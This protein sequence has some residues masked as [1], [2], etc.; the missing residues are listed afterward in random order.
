MSDVAHETRVQP[1]STPVAPAAVVAAPTPVAAVGSHGGT[2]QGDVHSLSSV[3]SG[4]S[5]PRNS[6]N[7]SGDQ[8]SGGSFPN[9]SSQNWRSLGGF[10]GGN[11][12]ADTPQL[13]PKKPDEAAKVKNATMGMPSIGNVDL[14][15][16]PVHSSND[17][18]D[19]FYH[20]STYGTFTQ[21]KPGS[22]K[23]NKDGHAVDLY[24]ARAVAGVREQVGVRGT[25]ETTG[26][27]GSAK[28]TG[29]AFALAE[30]GAD[31]NASIGSNGI[32]GNA[33]ASARA[34]IGVKG[35]ADLKSNALNIDGVD[36]LYA[37][38]GTH[39]DGFAEPGP[40]RHLR[41]C[42]HHRRADAAPHRLDAD[43][44]AADPVQF[45]EQRSQAP[46]TA[47]RGPGGECGLAGQGHHP[48]AAHID[49]LR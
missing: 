30:A 37:G 2:G 9:W 21:E 43:H 45:G 48:V 10:G 25:A 20:D 39:A 49:I 12:L 18:K 22:Y 32:Q 1:Q 28:A 34:G 33:N 46:V 35:D 16:V 11:R 36:P 7:I 3:F 44:P 17:G 4:L 38:I 13:D 40:R 42:G 41:R 26:K 8:K 24:T 5:E 15:G 31:A 23:Y 47:V 6:Y 29:D 14:T 19:G 27:Y